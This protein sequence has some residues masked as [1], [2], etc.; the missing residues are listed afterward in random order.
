MAVHKY[1]KDEEMFLANYS[2]GLTDMDLDDMVERFRESG[3]VASF[4]AVRPSQSFHLVGIQAD[5]V[6]SGIRS[7]QESDI[8]IN[9]GFFAFRHHIFEYMRP[10]DELVNAPFARLIAERQLVAY[11]APRFWCMDTFKEQQELTD[12][13]NA[14]D[15]P[16]EVWKR[17]ARAAQG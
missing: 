11:R 3:K 17:V 15:A 1:V 8:L 5:G 10:G 13:Y 2:D 12:L 7:V 6:V 16:W 14:G 4:V 9:G